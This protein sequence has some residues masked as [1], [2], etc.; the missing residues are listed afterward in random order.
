LG[1]AP[2]SPRRKKDESQ[3][4]LERNAKKKKNPGG[5]SG[6]KS[7]HQKKGKTQLSQKRWKMK[8][9]KRKQKNRS[10]KKKED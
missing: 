10:K 4:Y 3:I 6:K 2:D 9:N 1:K 5:I 8:K 7:N